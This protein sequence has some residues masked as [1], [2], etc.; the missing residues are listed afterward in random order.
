MENQGTSAVYNASNAPYLN[1]TL[2][3]MGGHASMY[4]DCLGSSVPS[5][6]HYVWME[7]G[8][9]VFTDHTFTT[10]DD[11]SASNSTSS[12]AHLS[13]QLN[14]AGKTWRAY[15]EDMDS[16]TG[17]CPIVSGNQLSLTPN[18]YAAKHDPFVF[19]QDVVGSPPSQTNA[20]CAAHHKA[21]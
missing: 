20:S 1:N 21:Y 11:P 5:E 6:P 8:T 2:M 12:T 18:F 17:A 3:M 9:N 7:A 14:G 15:Q 16:T 4:Q 13:T 10:D 19:F